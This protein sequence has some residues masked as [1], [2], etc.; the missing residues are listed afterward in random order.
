VQLAQTG[1]EPRVGS[2]GVGEKVGGRGVPV[3]V[4]LAE[5]G[6]L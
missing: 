4:P 6:Q 1:G 2:E 5:L 3:L